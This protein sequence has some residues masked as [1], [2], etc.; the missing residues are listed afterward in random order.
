MS[1][2][3]WKLYEDSAVAESSLV[4]FAVHLLTGWVPSPLDGELATDL[5]AS[6]RSLA[7]LGVPLVERDAIPPTEP[8]VTEEPDQGRDRHEP[9]VRLLR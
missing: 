9:K 1:R 4:A 8:I 2:R 3:Y 7:T 6:V 5:A